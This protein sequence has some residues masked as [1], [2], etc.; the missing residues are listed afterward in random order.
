M[1]RTMLNGIITK[2]NENKCNHGMPS[3]VQCIVT[4]MVTDNHT[5]EYNMNTETKVSTK[6][7]KDGEAQETALTLNWDGMTEDDLRALAQQALIVK[8]Q[9]S[10]RKNG[11][12]AEVTVNVV[13]HKVGTR[14]A[15]GPVNIAT[16]VANLSTEDKAA[17]LA[18]LQAMLAQ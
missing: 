13:D 6:A 4:N 14:A 7:T 1:H 16:A 15:R 2:M 12:P 9:G 5:T 11:I 10:W 17:L 8:L 18:K 3:C